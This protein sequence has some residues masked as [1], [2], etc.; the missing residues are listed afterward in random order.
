MNAL[1]FRNAILAL[2]FIDADE[3]SEG[4]T[5]E[6]YNRHD[7]AQLAMWESFRDN[8]VKFYTKTS[9]S[10]RNA[11]WGIIE[12]RLTRGDGDEQN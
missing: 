5:G 2:N 9:D 1:Q 7:R 6:K 12:K 8:P 4:L 10:Y 11:L 3:F